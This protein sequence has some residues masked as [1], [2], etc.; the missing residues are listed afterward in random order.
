MPNAAPVL[1]PLALAALLALAAMPARAHPHVWV[2]AKAEIDYASGQVTGIRHSWS[3]DPA[4]SAFVT[5]G[6]D[7][8]ADGKL[9]P[10]ELADLAAENTKGLAEFGYFTK[11]KVGGKEQ[12]FAEPAEPRMAMEGDTLV[13]SFLLP[14]KTPA[15]QGRGVVALEVYDPTYFVSFG[16][17]EGADAAKLAGAPAGCAATVTRPKAPEAK[18]AEAGK[19]GMTEAFFEALTAASNYGLQYAQRVL[20]ACP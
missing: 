4:Y 6:L 7:K 2:T 12:G 20:V 3:F 14:L 9:T 5:Q 15:A 19:P 17:A 18:T 16:L 8:N 10:D 1:R 11:L 13:M